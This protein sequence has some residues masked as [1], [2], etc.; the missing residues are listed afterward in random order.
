[1]LQLGRREGFILATQHGPIEGYGQHQ[2]GKVV[3]RQQRLVDAQQPPLGQALETRRPR[4]I[5]RGLRCATQTVRN[6]VRAFNAGGLAA[7]EAGSS[8]PRSAACAEPGV[9][10]AGASAIGSSASCSSSS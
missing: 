3:R 9:S 10:A 7:L 4:T 5:A 6:G 2:I 8:R 1:M